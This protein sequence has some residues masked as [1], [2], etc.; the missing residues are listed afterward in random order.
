M[1]K[2]TL[3]KGTRD[4][5]PAVMA[6]RQYILDAIR[7]VFQKFGFQP[8]ETPAME[9]LS[10]LTGKYGEEGDQLLFKILNSGDFLKEY[11]LRALVQGTIT[12]TIFEEFVRVSKKTSFSTFREKIAEVKPHFS[13]KENEYIFRSLED[14]YAVNELIIEL[15]YSQLADSS[16]DE[17]KIIESLDQLFQSFLSKNF[18]RNTQSKDLVTDELMSI[19]EKGLRY[20]LTVPF[21]RYVVMN[22]HEISSPF[23]RYQIQPVWRADRPQKGRYREFYQCDADVVGTDSLTCEAEIILMIREVFQSLKIEDYTIKINHRGVLTGLAELAGAK[24]NQTAL[25]V[26]IDKLDK[27]GEDK[28]KEELLSKGFTEKSLK[29]VF[30]ILNFQGTTSQKVVFLNDQFTKSEAGDKGVSQLSAVLRLLRDYNSDDKHVEF[31]IALARGLSYYT[32]CIFEV[33][34]NNVSIGSVSG[35]GRYDNLTAA[36]GDKENLSGVGFSFGVDRLYDAMEELNLFPKEAQASTKILICHFDE[37]T[38]RFGLKELSALRAAGISAE[39]YPDQA[40]M[41]KQLDY[42]NKKMIPY[43]I[44]IGSEETKNGFLTFKNMETGDQEKLTVQQII[45]KLKA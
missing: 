43:A 10:T 32:G 17:S 21:A 15:L 38:Q 44:V 20:D 23:K 27:I 45:Q 18:I 39:V 13:A 24:E 41:K 35:G 42:A 40:K 7:K 28:V 11:K 12:K 5:G 33:K 9:N 19:S 25:F 37:E 2:P 3:P 31:D 34:I 26:A 36:F 14:F 8:L 1:E 29:K 16:S 30:E 6:K 4:F 22:K